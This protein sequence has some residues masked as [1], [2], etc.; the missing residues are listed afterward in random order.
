MIIELLRYIRGYV[1]FEMNGDYPERLLNQLAANGISA[2][3]ISRSKSK[4]KAFVSVGDYFKI[5]G[6]RRKNRVRTRVTERHGLPFLMRRHRL[7]IGFAVGAMCCIIA[8]FI[9][10]GFIWNVK[11]VGNQSI[12]DSEIKQICSELGLKEGARRSDID[13]GRLKSRLALR[14]DKA[15]WVSVNIEGVRATVNISEITSEKEPQKEPCNLVA[16][17]DGIITA[18]EATSGSIS[19][20]VGQTVKKGELLV[21]GVTEFKDGTYRF[22]TAEGKIIAETEREISCFVPFSRTELVRS[23]QSVKRSAVSFFG[24]DIPLYLGSVKGLYETESAVSCYENGEA[25]LPIRVTSTVFYALEEVTVELSAEQAE[26]AAAEKLE[27]LKKA[28]LENAEILS[29]IKEIDTLSDGIRLT[30]RLKCRENIA[31]SDFILI[32]GEK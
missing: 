10:S 21:S 28:E 27:E 6:C 5:R 30:A 22:G 1:G 29:E 18:I 17:R 16:E 24:V 32:L 9:L 8:L 19:V 31:K 15:A 20:K 14:L 7:R 25:Y 23:G 26:A 12:T 3:G 13:V 11:V 2:W 4:L